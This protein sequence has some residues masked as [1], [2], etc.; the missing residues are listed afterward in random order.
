MRLIKINENIDQVEEMVMPTIDNYNIADEAGGIEI[1]NNSSQNA[2][3]IA[4]RDGR[5]K[6]E[7]TSKKNGD[8]SFALD[9]VSS[10]QSGGLNTCGNREIAPQNSAV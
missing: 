10:N 7:L 8:I 4:G 9:K 6:H 1:K 2:M 3:Q 5:I